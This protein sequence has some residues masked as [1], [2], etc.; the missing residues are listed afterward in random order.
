MATATAA[1]KPKTAPPKV[2]DQKMLI[3]GKWVDAASGKTFD[4][5]NPATGETICRVAEGVAERAPEG[6]IVRCAAQAGLQLNDRLVRPGEPDHA[7]GVLHRER[8]VVGPDVEPLLQRGFRLVPRLETS[9]RAADDDVDL[10]CGALVLGDER[11]AHMRRL[12]VVADRVERDREAVEDLFVVR[13]DLADLLEEVDR[14][15]VVPRLLKGRRGEE[16]GGRFYTPDGAAGLAEDVRYGGRGVTSVEEREL[17]N[18]PV[19]L[20]ALMG[21]MC[22]EWGYRRAVGLS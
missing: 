17:W 18:M 22:G 10:R 12:T 8:V 20:F 6:G 16:T 13:L 2:P 9:V 14:S 3:G 1:P 21:L 4:T 19:I 7:D 15:G 5:T 11:G